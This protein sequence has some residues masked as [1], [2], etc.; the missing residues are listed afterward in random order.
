M[1]NNDFPQQIDTFRTE[2]E[3]M[4]Q[5]F[6]CRTTL[7]AASVFVS[8]LGKFQ[9]QEVLWNMTLA[10][11][12]HLRATQD[13][14][15]SVTDRSLLN[16]PFIEITDGNEGVFSVKVGLD[17]EQIDEQVIKKAIIMIRNYKRLVIGRI[18]FGSM[19]A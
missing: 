17:L 1:M 18:E 8:F 7:P 11:L 16:C 12:A 19:H 9:G 2:L 3:R 4:G 13:R 6:I 14:N 10:T 15:T 5:N